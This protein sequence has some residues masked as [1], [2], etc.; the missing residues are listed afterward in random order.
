[1]N[2]LE[3]NRERKCKSCGKKSPAN[4]GFM[5]GLNFVC[6]VECAA[7]LA[8]QQLEKKKAKEVAK[9][10]RDHK[11]AQKARREA[12][13]AQKRRVIKLS[14]IREKLQKLV[15]Q[16]VNHVRDANKP[17]CTCGTTSPN[18]KYDAGHYRS[19]GACPELSYELTNI[20]RQCSLQCNQHG[21]GKR[22]EYREF[23]IAKYGKEHYEW[24]EGSHEPLP[25]D[26]EWYY[27][28]IDRY[29]SIIRE[30]GLKPVK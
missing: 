3:G 6:G 29:R 14:D 22:K 12:H 23:I 28:E 5:A 13:R 11:E 9:A 7:N 27:A 19:R 2:K 25:K 18:I 4:K 30:A 16:Y 24:L 10:K 15:N 21:S 17:C 20:H 26:R 1:M 8:K